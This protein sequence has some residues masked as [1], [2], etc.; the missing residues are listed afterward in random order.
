MAFKLVEFRNRYSFT[1]ILLL[2]VSG[3]SLLFGG[4]QKVDKKSHDYDALSLD[5]ESNSQWSLLSN[6]A[7][8]S[9]ESPSGQESTDYAYEHKET[10]VIITLNSVCGPESETDLEKLSKNLLLGLTDSEMPVQSRH[11]QVDGMAAL[12]STLELNSQ[13][14]KIQ[15]VVTQKKGC[16]YDFL[17]IAAPQ[18]YEKLHP[19]FL[20]FLRGFHAH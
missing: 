3:C 16:T 15:A 6:S 11:I 4:N 19:E 14:A 12:E 13:K 20:R 17:F 1:F 7:S 2:F 10:K 8:S 9:P 18:H 5:K